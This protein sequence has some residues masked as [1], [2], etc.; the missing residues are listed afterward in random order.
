MSVPAL[1]AGLAFCLWVVPPA[2]FTASFIRRDG[3]LWMDDFAAVAAVSGYCVILVGSGALAMAGLLTPEGFWLGG[4]LVTLL[5]VLGLAMKHR[6]R[7]ARSVTRREVGLV[8]L[9]I[10]VA[11]LASLPVLVTVFDRPDALPGSTPW[12][13]WDLA[14]QTA[15]LGHFPDTSIEW[16]QEVPFIKD[17]PAFTAAT[18][19][20]AASSTKPHLLFAAHVFRIASAVGAGLGIWYLS[21]VWG[22]NR[23][24]A[25]SSV[26]LLMAIALFAAKLVSYRP[27]SAGYLLMLAVPALAKRWLQGQEIIFLVVTS[28]GF[29]TLA[30]THG[31]AWTMGAILLIATM[32]SWFLFS[33]DRVGS[34]LARVGAVLVTAS[35][36]WLAVASVLNSAPAGTEHL[37]S[38]PDSES[39]VE[40][41]TWAFQSLLLSGTVGRPPT[42]IDL[43]DSAFSTGFQG[44]PRWVFWTVTALGLLVVVVRTVRGDPES[45]LLLTT[46][47]LALLGVSLVSSFFVLGWDTYVPRRTGI[48]RV[49]Q[50]AL[51]MVPLV[52]GVSAGRTKGR[53]I[54]ASI[55][56]A[57]LSL[58]VLAVGAPLTIENGHDQSAPPQALARLRSLTVEGQVLAN[59][60]TEGFIAS[61]TQANGALEGRAPYSDPPL[62][63]HAVDQ[64]ILARSFFAD[65]S[66]SSLDLTQYDL[67]LVS[68]TPWT[69]G[70]GRNFPVNMQ[71]LEAHPGLRLIQETSTWVAFQPVG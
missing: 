40:D 11:L 30:I 51:V 26:F 10:A 27:E 56:V 68:Q 1:L 54:A 47:V 50:A 71:A 21:R 65:P 32:A 9:P 69:I 35:V 52:V 70:T 43:A 33:E 42:V 7:P 2:V 4:S 63:E 24:G 36:I 8:M 29:A 6:L 39:D 34:K 23:Y 12:Y 57:A 45:R 15:E 62:L 58:A 22:A 14:R 44:I 19:G 61:N 16:G 18:A 53:W 41:P 46:L 20:L 67:V 13:Y 59:A 60:Y 28:L 31:I 37:V 64:I 49:G 55:S 66:N 25:T 5:S 17:Y 3:D 48:L 38:L